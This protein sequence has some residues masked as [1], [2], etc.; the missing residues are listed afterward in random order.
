MC[1]C[2]PKFNKHLAE[3]NTE[4]TVPFWTRSGI[5]APFVETRKLDKN[6]RGKPKAVIASCCPFCG[7]KYA[8]EDRSADS[9]P[10]EHDHAK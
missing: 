10:Q 6:K 1:D 4:I 5:L 8:T 3:H 2:I 9:P 7:E